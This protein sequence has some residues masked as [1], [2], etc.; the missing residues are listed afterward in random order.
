MQSLKIILTLAWRNL[1]R[2]RSRTI[3]MISATLFAVL[4]AVATKSVQEGMYDRQIDNVV[5]F[6]SGYLQIQNPAF[7][8][9][10][11]IDN[12]FEFSDEITELVKKNEDI[13]AY[14]PHL[15]SFA[16]V[17]EKD[18]AKGAMITGTDPKQEAQMTGL[19][20]R[21][22]KGKYFSENDGVM[23]GKGLANYLKVTIGDS[24]IFM[25][26]GYHG[27][28]AYSMFPVVGILEFGSPQLN[29]NMVYMPIALAQNMLSANGLITSLSINP[30]DKDDMRKIQNQL[31]PEI[32]K[33]GLTI[34]NWEEL[35][36]DLKNTIESDRKSGGIT[37]GV[38]YMIIGFVIYGTLLMMI[39]E[40]LREFSMLIAVGM[41]NRLLAAT[42]AIECAIMAFLGGILGGIFSLPITFWLEKFPIRLEAGQ[43][44]AYEVIGFEPVITA[45]TD[46]GIIFSQTQL[47]VVMSLLLSIYPVIKILKI[48][49]LKGMR[50]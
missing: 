42:L 14:T 45:R 39:S 25:G 38:L 26:Q 16:L 24:V 44:K 31:L 3:I 2:N 34:K 21:V 32:K 15:E 23:I 6:S 36:P 22:I 8:D 33:S 35:M 1:W 4:L 10:R 13:K 37:L 29:D 20:K 9:D 49:P 40:R 27:S 28:S 19:D 17:A 7:A 11:T 5:T 43:A 30:K 50:S 18:I 46:W 41:K 48:D 12:A 47:V